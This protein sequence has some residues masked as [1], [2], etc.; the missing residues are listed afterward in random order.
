MLGVGALDSIKR[1]NDSRYKDGHSID[2]IP[3]LGY[4]YAWNVAD[5]AAPGAT[6]C[7]IQKGIVV[8]KKR[9]AVR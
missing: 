6:N 2:E 8:L 5:T 9:Y 3:R 7:P 1:W 4:M